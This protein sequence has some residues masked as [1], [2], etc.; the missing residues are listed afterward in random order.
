MDFVIGSP[1]SA[2][3]KSY[4]H[5]SI[6]LIVNRLTK[7]VH[8]KPV[9]IPIDAPGLPEVILNVVVRHHGLPDSIISDRGSVFTSKIWSFLCYFLGIKQRL[10]T[11][12]SDALP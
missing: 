9:H 3:W 1:I 7:I 11:A 4:S 6:L 8:Y 2:D 12:P 5:D 10:S